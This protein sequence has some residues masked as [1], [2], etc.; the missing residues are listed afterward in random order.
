[1]RRALQ[2]TPYLLLHR[3][4]CWRRTVLCHPLGCAVL[5]LLL[6]R[7]GALLASLD[8][9]SKSEVVSAAAEVWKAVGEAADG[10]ASPVEPVALEFR[11]ELGECPEQKRLIAVAAS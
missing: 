11:A 4:L 5:S 7:L 1:M 10:I 9:D 3:S 8:Q 2:K 6:R